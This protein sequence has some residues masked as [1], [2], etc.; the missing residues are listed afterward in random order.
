MGLYQVAS[1]Q[2]S[3]WGRGPGSRKGGRE[4]G[5]AA[6]LYVRGSGY[7][8]LLGTFGRELV[9]GQRNKEMA[10]QKEIPHTGEG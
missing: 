7:R 10:E 2:V 5:R 1:G 9:P 3:G 4:E 8:F 6:S